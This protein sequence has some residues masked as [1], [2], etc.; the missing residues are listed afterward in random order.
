[1][2]VITGTNNHEFIYG[3]PESDT[4][5]GAVG[6]DIFVFN[7]QQS[8][9]D[10]VTDFGAMYFSANINGAQ[11]GTVNPTTGVAAPPTGSAATGTATA[12]LNK[13]NTKFDWNATITGLDLGGQTASTTDNVTA[14]HFHRAPTGVSG[15]VVWGFIGAPFNNTDNDQTINPVTGNVT[16]QWDVNEGNNTTLTAVAPGIR[17]NELYIN[18]HTAPFPAGEIR[19]QMIAQDAGLDQIDLRGSGI[20]DFATLQQFMTETNGSAMISMLWNGQAS[21]MLLTDVPMSLLRASDFIFQDA[22]SRGVTGTAGADQIVG[23]GG[24]DWLIGAGGSDT[25]WGGGG[26]DILDGGQGSDNL[27]GDAGADQLMG[28]S[29]ADYLRGMEDSDTVWGDD[30]DDA[31]VNGNMGNDEVHGGAGADTVFGGRDNDTVYGDDGAD[32]VSGDLGNDVLYGG[33]GADRFSF[34]ANSGTDRVADFSFADGDRVMLAT[35]QAY[36]ITTV[37]GWGAISLGADQTIELT[38]VSAGSMNAGWVVFS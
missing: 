23:A 38:G 24:G 33:A 35:G 3:T 30:G 19:G 4:L 11:E 21:S 31:H 8:G 29:E 28:G 14:A 13:A 15:G 25:L 1:M 26:A 2:A 22:S 5:T 27:R 37:N 12:V 9:T 16:G 10:T 17:N 20:G 18:F 34:L 32:V 6:N 36:S 7:A